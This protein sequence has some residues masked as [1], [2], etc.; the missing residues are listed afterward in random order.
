MTNRTVSAVLTV[1]GMLFFILAAFHVPQAGPVEAV[2][3]G[4]AFWAAATL[5]P[6]P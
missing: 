4:L 2:P 6:T 1:V 5:I 3:A